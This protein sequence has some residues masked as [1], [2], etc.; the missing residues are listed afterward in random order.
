MATAKYKRNKRGQFEARIWDGTYTEAGLKHRVSIYSRKSS[1]DLERKVNEFIS[2]RDNLSNVISSDLS[3]YEYSLKWL[4]VAKA[5]REVNTREMYEEIIKSKFVGLDSVKISDI[6]HSHFQMIINEN[7]EHPRRCEQIALTF[8]QVI[9]S[10]V[11]DKILPKSALDDILDDISMPKYIKAPKRPLTPL[12]KDAVKTVEMEPMKMVFVYVLYYLGL[13]RGEALALTPASFNWDENTVSI[14][15]VIIFSKEGSKV[16]EY[17]KSNNGIRT[18]PLPDEAVEKIKPYIESLPA[19]EYLFH[20][21]TSRIM[22]ENSFRR[23]WESILTNLNK[24]VGYNPYKRDRGEKPIQGLTPHIFR[25]NYCTEL[26]YLVPQISTKMIAKLLGDTEKMV[27]EVYSH[28][29][30][31]KENTKEVIQNI[32]L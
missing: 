27:L 17:P 23:M 24:A 15:N 7:I 4:Q 28:I 18:I 31:E 19:D 6:Q 9:K 22:T 26:C 21:S 20:G 13:R 11:R 2:K 10:A 16:K 30:E 5:A 32:K 14:Q 12:E 1:A 25:H 3:F 8:K 29:V